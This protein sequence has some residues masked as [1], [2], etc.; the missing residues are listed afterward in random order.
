ML[1]LDKYIRQQLNGHLAQLEDALSADA[2]SIVSPILPGLD[3]RVR[4]ALDFLTDPRKHLAIIL[5]TPGGIVEVVERIVGT[6]RHRYE[7]VTV[8]VPDKAMSAGTI[9]ALAAD[10]IMMDHFSCLGPVDPQVEK[11]GRLVPALSYLNQFERLNQKAAQGTLTTAEYALLTKLDLGELHQFEQARE[12]S[13]ELIIRW[14]PKYKFKDWTRTET[15]G[16]LVTEELKKERA[17]EIARI[18]NNT[19]RWHSHSR[20]IDMET[21]RSE[22]GLVIEDFSQGPLR[23]T[24]H[25]YFDLLRDYQ[26]QKQLPYFV[27]TREYF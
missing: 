24:I 17:R 9:L 12:L 1:P 27:Q 13:I 8:I 26:V 18:L 5:E 6:I 4:D 3:K 14:L 15:R 10:N 22:L 16:M 21:L 25:D 2:L 23:R 20:G 11:E 7:R 19:E